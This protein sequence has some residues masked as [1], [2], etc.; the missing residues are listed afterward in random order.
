MLPKANDQKKKIC[1][2]FHQRKVLMKIEE[3]AGVFLNS[4]NFAPHALLT[5]APTSGYALNL[6]LL[7]KVSKV[8]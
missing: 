3:M 2:I 1:Q 4:A 7:I 8:S 6:K 5:L